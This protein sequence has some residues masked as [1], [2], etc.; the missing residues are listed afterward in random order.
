MP[1]SEMCLLWISLGFWQDALREATSDRSA[2]WDEW[3]LQCL[4]KGVE[5]PWTLLDN[6][7]GFFLLWRREWQ[8]WGV[9]IQDFQAIVSLWVSSHWFLFI[10]FFHTCGLQKEWDL[11]SVSIEMLPWQEVSHSKSSPALNP[12]LLE[13]KD[14]VS[15]LCVLWLL[16]W[17]GHIPMSLLSGRQGAR[18]PWLSG[19]MVGW[20]CFLF[21]PSTQIW[22][23]LERKHM[24]GKKRFG[25][26]IVFPSAL[27]TVLFTENNISFPL[28]IY[29]IFNWKDHY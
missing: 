22:V 13:T 29:W 19:I 27:S 12:T 28:C 10:P 17:Q 16:D 23:K 2:P 4:G 3:K 18:F 1:H 6:S 21:G 25:W 24:G 20:W 8:S 7:C 26:H 5:Q 11:C 15:E 9:L 14:R